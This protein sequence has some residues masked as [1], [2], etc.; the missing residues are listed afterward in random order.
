MSLP[1][2]LERSMISTTNLTNSE[3]VL[4]FL[5][6]LIKGLVQVEIE[7]FDTSVGTFVV[8]S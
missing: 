1:W 6:L 7:G 2:T 5:G 8:F 3:F 4:A